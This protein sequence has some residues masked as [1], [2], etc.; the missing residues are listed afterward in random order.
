MKLVDDPETA[1]W[2]GQ[3]AGRSE[4]FDWDRG[5]QTKNRQH[6]VEHADIETLFRFPLVFVGRITEPTRPETRWLALGQ[7]AES[8]QLAL[9]FTRRGDKLRP[10]SC[11]PMR[12]DERR[13]YEDTLKE[14]SAKEE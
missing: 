10:I 4:N 14:D 13:I 1:E 2:L 12:R 8:R 7:D 5:N 11:R 6:G 9:V 3:F